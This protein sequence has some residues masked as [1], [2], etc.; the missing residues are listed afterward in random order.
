MLRITFHQFRCWENLTIEAPLGCITL[1]KGASGA[2]K[3]TILQGITW[4]LYGNLR[5]VAPNH[6]EKSRTNVCIELPYNFNGSDG[7]L[8]ITRQKNPNRFI[9]THGSN[10]YEDKVAQSIIDD[11][12][13]A[14]DIWLASC[15]IGQGCRNSFLTAPNTGKMELLNSIAFHEEDPTV[16][17]ERIDTA[18]SEIDSEYKGKLTIFTNNLNTFQNL[19]NNT[20]ISKALS[21]DQVA[22]ITSQIDGYTKEIA[23]LQLVKTQR[24]IDIGVLS[25]LQRQLT[26]A[27]TVVIVVP[28]ADTTLI[29]TH[30]KYGG[31]MSQFDDVDLIPA[32]ID[33]I[34]GFI[35]ILQRRD[36]LNSEIKRLDN[37]LLPYVNFKDDTVYTTEDYQDAISKETSLRDNQRLAHSLG[38]L[39]S[40]ES[41][42]ETIQR[43]RNMLTVQERLKLERERDSLQTQ[44][45]MLEMEHMRQSTPIKF[46][47]IVPENIHIPDYS[48]YS[49]TALSEE[50]SELSK[51]QGAIQA[52]IQHLQKGRDVLQCPQ[53]NTSLRYQQ[54]TLNLADTGPADLAEL[55]TSQQ[56]LEGVNADVVRVN[57]LIQSLTAAEASDRLNYERSLALEQRRLDSLR[58]RT[59]QLELEKQRK[60]IANQSRS[61][62]IHS[63]NLDLQKSIATINEMGDLTV[64]PTD[65]RIL[66]VSEVDQMHNSIGRLSSIIIVTSPKVSSQQ[67]Q[68]R[69]THQDLLLKNGIAITAYNDYLET[70]PDYF[71]TVPIN[72]VQAYISQLRTYWDQV[73]EIAEERI[74]IDRLK[75]SLEDQIS[76]IREKIAEDPTPEI[77]RI[78]QE[79]STLRQSLEL[80]QKAYHAIQSHTQITAEREEVMNLNTTL[81][82]LQTFRQYAVETEC[83]ILQQVVDSINAS[84]QGV[85]NT[86]F[87]RDISI[88]LNLFKTMKTTKNVK[89]VANFNI[90]Y[91]GG[92]FDNINQMSG[93]EGDRASLALTLALKRLSS[94]PILMLDESLASL[95]L[96]MKESALRTIRQNTTD[97]VLIIMHDGIEGQYDFVQNIDEVTE[98]RY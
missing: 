17:I 64:L 28:V 40:E 73:R 29:E 78:T 30:I 68:S 85:C 4:C 49:T 56:E 31:D 90:S 11:T 1:I 10:I 45:G 12:F 36:D 41:I 52:H 96:N 87:D 67:I 95:D 35:P 55:A 5:L 98:G 43:Y 93:G 74:R 88:T 77:D 27:N 89:P 66:S 25:N 48:K 97:T 21:P 81:G 58:E 33:T 38:V 8:N 7:I 65:K 34:T 60:D 70:I 9:V 72:T 24:N 76:V 2:G 84:I 61:Q 71:R 82:D 15:Y 50:L 13:G 79:I 37:L 20:D 75:T 16:Y 42:N 63:L 94:C 23:S 18:I 46:P 53:C 69:L 32:Y 39:Y 57:K 54:G 3:T 92:S 44:I 86:L 22:I 80:S 26:I 14:Y 83:R 59:K 51:K 62:Q 19:L 91:Q 47:D 6:L